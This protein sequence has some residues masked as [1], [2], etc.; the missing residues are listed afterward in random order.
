MTTKEQLL[1][2]ELEKAPDS[3]RNRLAWVADCWETVFAVLN[4][5]IRTDN[6]EL[7]SLVEEL[8]G[9]E[10]MEASCPPERVDDVLEDYFWWT[11]R[12]C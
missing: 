5:C 3:I 12:D 6:P 4:D 9:Y 2:A 8:H 11:C 1:K 10:S 7:L